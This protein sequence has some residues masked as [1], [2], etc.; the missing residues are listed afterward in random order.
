[1]G[2]R[3]DI[4]AWNRA[5]TLVFGDLGA[6]PARERTWLRLLF[7]D[8]PVRRR[9]A[10]WELAVRDYLALYRAASARHLDDPAHAREIAELTATSDDFRRWWSRHDVA[11]PFEG[12]CEILHPTAGRLSFAGTTLSVHPNPDRWLSVDTPAAGSDTAGKLAR[13]LD[14]PPADPLSRRS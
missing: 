7:T 9:F 11:G 2:W 3:T 8:T 1:M 5:A 6:V 4:L 10:N 13:L 14:E 12:Y